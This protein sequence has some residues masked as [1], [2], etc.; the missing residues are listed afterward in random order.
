MTN[1]ALLIFTIAI[2]LSATSL[3]GC[4]FAPAIDS[5]K[6]LGLTETDRQKLL[7]K[8]I[9]EFQDALYWGKPDEA[10]MY[11]KDEKKGAL[12]EL[13]FEIGKGER[14]TESS[15]ER[16]EF[17]EGSYHSKVRVLVRS[18]KVPYY[19]VN[20]R[21]DAQEWEFSVSG[22]WLLTALTRGAPG[23]VTTR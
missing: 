9:K 11:V 13:I 18:F 12:N 14:V 21:I 1:K 10:M 6:K 19:I 20:Q 4:I 23:S 16:T 7:G 8:S 5:F 2:A 22:G 15:I 17:D 3:Q